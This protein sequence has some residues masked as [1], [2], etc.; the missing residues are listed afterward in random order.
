MRVRPIVLAILLTASAIAARAEDAPD[1]AD[2]AGLGAVSEQIKRLLPMAVHDSRLVLNQDA[3]KGTAETPEQR[4]N[5]MA[6]RLAKRM[7]IA[8]D[9]VPA[10]MIDSML[11]SASGL[12][13]VDTFQSIM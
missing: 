8:V 13:A 11:N 10:H 9:K 3:W 4:R 5:N 12:P 2:R 1:D 6:E 7:H